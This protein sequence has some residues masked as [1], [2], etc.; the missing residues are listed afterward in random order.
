MD[1]GFP[2]D[3]KFRYTIS[4]E[5]KLVARIDVDYGTEEVEYRTMPDIQWYEL[6]FG[7]K[8]SVTMEEFKE[9]MLN[10]TF[11]RKFSGL[12]NVMA[13][14][15]ATSLYDLIIKFK[16]TKATDDMEVTCDRIQ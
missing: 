6:P 10:R 14:N 7:I 8:E 3:G 4:N 16:G 12:K 1:Y 13:E 2:N 5:G 11:D 9:F 15:N